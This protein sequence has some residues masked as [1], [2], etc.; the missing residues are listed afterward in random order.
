MLR[1]AGKKWALITL[2]VDGFK[3]ALPVI[4]ASATC[5]LYG[6]IA[7]LGAVLG[8]LFPVWLGFK[9]GKG[10]ATTLGGLLGLY[11]PIGI[12]TCVVWVLTAVLFHYSS[13]AALVAVLVAS[14]LM[15]FMAGKF[16][17][18]TVVLVFIVSALVWFRHKDNILR[19]LK[20]KEP[21]IGR[22]RA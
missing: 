8:H 17:V 5:P 7:L 14:L 9:G 1:I 12:A 11:L 19:L 15:V 20:G 6:A 10:V 22:K 2:F 18:T 16:G 13:L 4:I 3:G 21:K